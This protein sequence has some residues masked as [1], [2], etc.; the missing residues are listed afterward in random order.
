MPKAVAVVA[1]DQ[2]VGATNLE[3]VLYHKGV[4]SNHNMGALGSNHVVAK[5]VEDFNKE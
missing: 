5:D 4:V 1:V 3:D 2:H